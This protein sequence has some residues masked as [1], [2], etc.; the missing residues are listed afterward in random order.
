MLALSICLALLAALGN[1]GASVLQRQGAAATGTEPASARRGSWMAGLVHRRVWVWGAALLAVSGILQA[2]ALATGPLSVVQPVMSTE[3]MFT[4]VVGGVVFRQ[5]PDTRTRWAFAAMAVGL[6]VFLAMAD[7]SGGRS[8]VPLADWGWTALGTGLFVAVMGVVSLRLSPA[9][10]AAVLGTATAT[11]F[12]VTAALLKDALGR[13]PDGI[14]AVFTTWQPYA[15]VGVGL[16][17]FVLLQVTLRAGSL[18]AS[19]PALTLGDA[20][21]SVVLG[22]TLFAERVHLGWRVVF[23]VLA[24]AVLVAGCVQLAR[25]PL[26]TDDPE[27]SGDRW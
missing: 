15:A 16:A 20:L 6:G 8:T 21:L 5:R 3:L 19:Q 11:G 14:G 24:L 27:R 26:V 22:V 18:V 25:S 9:P 4:L 7:P 17:S 13:V 1:A 2:L 10:R 12:A 23:E